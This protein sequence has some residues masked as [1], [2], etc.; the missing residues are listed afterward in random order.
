MAIAHKGKCVVVEVNGLKFCPR[1]AEK[2]FK[3]ASRVAKIIT[4]TYKFCP[5]CH[6]ALPFIDVKECPNCE[7]VIPVPEGGRRETP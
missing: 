3:A 4:D 7:G 1:C 5:H 6:L 2:Q